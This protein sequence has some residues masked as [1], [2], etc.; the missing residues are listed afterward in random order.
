MV[1]LRKN[2][3]WRWYGYVLMLL[4]LISSMSMHAQNVTIRANNGSCLASTPEGPNGLEYDT[5]Y[6]VG[7]FATWEHEQLSMVLTASDYTDLTSN[8]QLANPAN[9]IF[10]NGNKIQI[11]KGFTDFPTCYLSLTLPKGFRFTGYSIVFSKYSE[12]K[13]NN[14]DDNARVTFNQDLYETRFGETNSTFDTYINNATVVRDAS[15]SISRNSMSKT[16]MGNVLYFMLDNT[17]SNAAERA[18]ITLESAEFF[19]TAEADY[20]PAIVPGAASCVSAIDIP[21]HTSK[22]DYGNIVPRTYNDAMRESYNSANVQDLT[23]NFTLYE[24]GSI[25]DGSNFDGSTGKVVDYKGGSISVEDGYFRIGAEN[26]SNPGNDEHIYYIETPSYVLLSDNVTKNP[27]GYRIVGAE[28]EYKYGQTNLYSGG[29]IIGG[30]IGNY[31]L[32]VYDKEGGNPEEVDVN[33]GNSSGTVS[34]T[35]LNND[36]IKIGVVGTGLIK[37]NLTLQALNPYVDHMS[38]VCHDYHYNDALHLEQAFMASDFSLNG[39]GI[40]FNLPDDS[41]GHVVDITFE[42]LI[43]KYA[44]ESYA[45]GSSR[46]NSR[47]SFVNSEHYNAFGSGNDNNVYSNTEEAMNATGERIFVDIAGTTKFRFNNASDLS[48]MD[49][50]LTEYPF[51]LANYANSPNDG[52]FDKFECMVS[53]DDTNM[54][55]YVFTTDETRY[56]IAPTTAIQHR[57]YAF[58]EMDLHVKVQT[59]SPTVQFVPIYK[60]ALY[61]DYGQR[62]TGDFY[63]AI[64]TADIG[65][66]KGYASTDKIY[67]IIDD[68]IKGRS[69]G[70]E[71]PDATDKILYL[72]LSGLA[73]VYE[74]ITRDL[75]SM[76]AFV[77]KLS[78]NCIIFMPQGQAAPVDNVA[79]M[80][81]SGQFR[82]T[83]NIVLTDKQ[84]FYSPYDIQMDADRYVRYERL[85]TSDKNGRVSKASVILPFNITVDSNGQHTNADESTPTFSLHQMQATNCLSDEGVEDPDETFVFFPAISPVGNVTTANT[86]YLVNVLTPPSDHYLSFVVT[87]KGSTIK[88][89]TGMDPTTYNYVGESASGSSAVGASGTVN[90]NFSCYANYSGALLDRDLGTFFYYA[91]NKFLSS[92]QLADSY[93]TVYQYPFR[94]YYTATKSY[95]V[96]GISGMNVVLGENEGESTGINTLDETSGLVMESGNGMMHITASEEQRV[97]IF[98]LSGVKMFDSVIHAGERKTTEI[99]PGIYIVNGNK[100]VVR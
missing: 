13:K 65:E 38:V 74:T 100:V 52:E 33:S 16:D 57:S 67:Q 96:K 29:S 21:F 46:H 70:D 86:P 87:Q 71:I 98:S 15:N 19:F 49:G 75:P 18:L 17:S 8:G 64:V 90:Y 25:V 26:A 22:V 99:P 11:A 47:Y 84:P 56:N 44:D 83:N 60:G 73:G 20:T 93:P 81:S 50:I 7:G 94:V 5:F 9:N 82:A 12:T 54:T 68:A 41:D 39:D 35:G 34:L 45:D 85:L 76:E 59:Y 10:T 30:A 95:N 27:I 97:E 89:T 24:A 66:D 51:S 77:S 36:A 40:Y 55:C 79:Y 88:A 3:K 63:G 32:K 23:G 58:Y 14:L 91:N 80:T 61:S 62:T 37:V 28:I 78:P 4:F 6:K 69:A 72:D 48:T 53:Y 2:I 42:D 1:N 43:S 31:T 92:D